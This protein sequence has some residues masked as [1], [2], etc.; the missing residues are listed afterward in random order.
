MTGD[1]QVRFCEEL[2]VK[3]PRLTRL[4][5]AFKVSLPYQQSAQ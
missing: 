3:F 1:C 4:T 5:A 2:G